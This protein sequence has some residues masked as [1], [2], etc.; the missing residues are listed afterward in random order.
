MAKE[1]SGKGGGGSSCAIDRLSAP[2]V[3]NCYPAMVAEGIIVQRWLAVAKTTSDPVTCRSNLFTEILAEN[4]PGTG[5]GLSEA[6]LFES[7]RHGRLFQHGVVAF[8]RVGRRDV[9]DGL[10]QPAIV[11]PVYPF[12][13][14][15]LDCLERPPWPAPVDDLGFVKAVDGFGEGIV[16]T[17]AD[18]AHRRLD[19]RF[20]QALGVFDRDV[21][22]APV[23]V[24][25]EPAAMHRP[26]VM[27]SLLQ[28]VEHEA[29][30][31]C[32]RDTP[33]DDATG[34]GVDD[35]GDVDEAR[36]G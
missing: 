13:R 35:K 18:A 32:P 17:V 28:R 8:L 26:P 6:I 2:F 25:H 31:R 5:P 36:P 19:T 23:A 30:V 34:V 7:R 12:Q 15:E 22:A 27:E 33:A 14:R 9:A 1:R 3:L 16:V 21:L 4:G 24:M 11:E 20:R 29:G 10:Q